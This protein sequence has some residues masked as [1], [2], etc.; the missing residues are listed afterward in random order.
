MSFIANRPPKRASDGPPWVLKTSEPFWV[1]RAVELLLEEEDVAVDG[2]LIRAA[3]LH[4]KVSAFWQLKYRLKQHGIIVP[5]PD[6]QL[7]GYWWEG[8]L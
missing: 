6:D 8:L 2:V 4:P 7:Y 3:E 5:P 1:D